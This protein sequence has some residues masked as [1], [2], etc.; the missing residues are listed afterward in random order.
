MV[1][2]RSAAVLVASLGLAAA[3]AAQPVVNGASLNTRI[4]NDFPNS[5][6]GTTNTFP[7]VVRISDA[8]LVNSPPAGFANRHNWRLSADGG[9]TNATFMN[10]HSYS[11]FADVTLSGTGNGEIG[12]QLS[13]WWSQNVDGNLMLNGVSG[14]VAAF[15][16][17]LPFYSFTASQSVNY[18]KGT[19]VRVGFEYDANSNTAADP[20]AIR[21][22]YGNLNS[23]WLNF[24]EGNPGEGFGSWGALNSAT[25]GGYLQVV[26][27]QTG[28]GDL[29]GTWANI[30]YVPAPGSM[31]LL[32]LGGLLAA[33]RRRRV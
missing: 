19:T 20:G 27:A 6:L 15:G 13:P 18:V 10:S 14:E 9:A 12:I 17:R 7:G 22:W 32:A 2:Q 16:G 21:Y 25:A 3:A 31:G 24:D 4:F 33:R 23:G 8:N 29:V 30:S 1:M 26:G 28:T 11:L 5:T